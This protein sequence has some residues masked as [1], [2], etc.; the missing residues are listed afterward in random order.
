MTKH[1]K[2]T[3]VIRTLGTAGE[4]YQQELDSLKTQTIKPKEII[5][6]IPEGHTLPK[7]TCGIERYVYVKKGMVAQRALPYNEVQTEWI[8]VIDDDIYFP[9]DGVEKLLNA[10][11]EY[12]ADVVS[13]DV[14]NNAERPLKSEIIML[15]SGR[16]RAR[17]YDHKWG[18]KVMRTGG[19]SYNKTPGF[20]ILQSQTNAGACFICRKQDFNKIRFEDEQWLDMLPYPIG[21]DQIMYYKMYLSGLRI[22]THYGTGIEH[23]DGGSNLGNKEKE[24]KLIYADYYFRRVFFDRFVLKPEKSKIKSLWSCLCIV[25]FY[26]F[27]MMM[28][29][30][31][32]DTEILRIK[33]GAL[34]RAQEFLKSNNYGLLP[35]VEKKI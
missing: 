4:K 17:R 35:L 26:I 23:L 10:I 18:Y 15:F 28:S 19:Y 16:M 7:E 30:L 20:G 27:G 2:Y 1:M 9:P 11:K 3:A 24:K 14:Y 8:L 22:L 5:V 21:E 31:K 12:D 33:Y 13:P 25:Y 34:H 29:V 6:Y 32:G